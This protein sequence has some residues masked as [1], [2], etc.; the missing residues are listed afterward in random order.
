[1]CKLSSD[2]VSNVSQ[3]Q[4][5]L[6]HVMG[7]SLIVLSLQQPHSNMLTYCRCAHASASQCGW[8]CDA[9]SAHAM[10]SL[11]SV[12]LMVIMDTADGLRLPQDALILNRNV[13]VA[14]WNMSLRV[15]R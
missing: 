4:L 12:G 15:D 11:I 9:H 13:E 7:Q 3:I 2:L 10:L 6:L 8:T 14:S 1:M 5:S